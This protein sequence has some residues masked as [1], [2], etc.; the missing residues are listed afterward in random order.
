MTSTSESSTRNTTALWYQ[1]TREVSAL[2]DRLEQDT[3]LAPP[4][5]E[6]VTMNG[7]L[8]R[9]VV[10]LHSV[11]VLD[12]SR[13]FQA[14]AAASRSL[15]EIAI[16]C[17]YLLHRPNET[18]KSLVDWEESLK[19]KSAQRIVRSLKKH[20]DPLGTRLP[21]FETFLAER[22]APIESL[23]RA[24]GWVKRGKAVHP[25]RWDNKN[26][27][28]ACAHADAIVPPELE[29]LLGN[30]FADF[31]NVNLSY[32]GALVHGTGLPGLR[33]VD[34]DT[35]HAYS[36]VAYDGASAHGLYIAGV[37][38]MLFGTWHEM[39]PKV[40]LLSHALAAANR[41]ADV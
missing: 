40:E 4:A 32:L 19:L 18:T 24:Q 10:W 7:M 16:D 29:P 1:R 22:T 14:L 17:T 11:I 15:C 3:R 5:P 26:L 30:G 20:R 12:S 23:R 8:Q 25:N 27:P 41:V 39:R 13:H 38:S 31:Y 34:E 33:G 36:G 2:L 35:M 28:D 21:R 6:H 37:V 9:A